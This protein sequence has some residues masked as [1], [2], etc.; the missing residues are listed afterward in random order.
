METK[1]GM[2]KVQQNFVNKAKKD[3][4]VEEVS[5]SISQ[6]IMPYTISK[7]AISDT[8]IIKKVKTKDYGKSWYERVKFFRKHQLSDKH[9]YF[10]FDTGMLELISSFD[11]IIGIILMLLSIILSFTFPYYI[12]FNLFAFGVTLF[13]IG[14]ITLMILLAEYQYRSL[15]MYCGSI[16]F[17]DG[18]GLFTAI[19]ITVSYA[20]DFLADHLNILIIWHLAFI[21]LLFQLYFVTHF[22]VTKIPMKTMTDNLIKEQ[23]RIKEL[24]E[25]GKNCSTTDGVSKNISASYRV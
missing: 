25:S 16:L 18:M 7:C 11:L 20:E 1:D 21:I 8:S 24:S 15:I 17:I 19:I 22:T 5:R 4:K 9:K 14:L 6:T 12:T 23:E 2:T 3:D 10:S 13:I